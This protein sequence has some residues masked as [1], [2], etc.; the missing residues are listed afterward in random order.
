LQ[1]ELNKKLKLATL[2]AVFGNIISFLYVLD[3]NNIVCDANQLALKMFE[4]HLIIGSEFILEAKKLD[5]VILEESHIDNNLYFEMYYDS[6]WFKVMSSSMDYDGELHTVVSGVDITD[7]K[8]ITVRLTTNSTT[9]SMTGILN[10]AV[11]IEY[12]ERYT[13]ELKKG[14]NNFSVCFLDLDNLKFINDN[15]GHDCGDEF[16]ITVVDIVRSL[17]RSTDIFCRMGGDE[18]LLLFAKCDAGPVNEIM[19]SVN[20]NLFDINN[21]HDRGFSY[22]ISYGVVAYSAGFTQSAEDILKEVDEEMYI[23]KKT[24]KKLN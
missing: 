20:K 11:G 14:G 5:V 9:D 3:K 24:N 13:Y 18:F 10:R 23:M 7:L 2:N 6:R 19:Q 1:T 4:N 16:I 21:R 17:I 12:L 22:Y 8:M 15:F